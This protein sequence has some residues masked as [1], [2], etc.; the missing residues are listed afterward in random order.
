MLSPA[1]LT[2]RRSDCH[3]YIVRCKWLSARIWSAT[4]SEIG[5][6][7]MPEVVKIGMVVEVKI[8][9]AARWFTPAEVSWMNLRFLVMLGTMRAGGRKD[10]VA[11]WVADSHSSAGGG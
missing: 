8:G 9:C 10:I 5:G 4:H 7:W 1:A 2:Q 3:L 6:P 11:R